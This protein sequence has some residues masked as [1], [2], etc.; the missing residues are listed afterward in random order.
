M[1]INLLGVL[2]G[3]TSAIKASIEDQQTSERFREDIQT[4]FKSMI[5]EMLT[6]SIQT[7]SS[8]FDKKGDDAN[9]KNFEN[10]YSVGA[11]KSLNNNASAFIGHSFAAP[12]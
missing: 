6:D 7:I 5:E 9:Q 3:W 10:D 8:L 4:L 1:Q 11:Q 12:P 2:E